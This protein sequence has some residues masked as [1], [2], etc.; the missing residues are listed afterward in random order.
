MRMLREVEN[1]QHH[2]RPPAGW[3]R[4]TSALFGSFSRV[5]DGHD[6]ACHIHTPHAGAGS[7]GPLAHS[8]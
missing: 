3:G 5:G 7:A 2:F 8:T 4:S 1:L 6:A